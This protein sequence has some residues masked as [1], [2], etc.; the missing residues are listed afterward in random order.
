MI[1]GSGEI[2]K[3]IKEKKLLEG[4]LDENIEGAGVDL[5]IDKIFRLKSGA[6]LTV[7]E[8]VLPKLEE[9]NEK[10]FVLKPGEYVLIQTIEKVNIPLELCAR[11]L[12][13]STLQRSGVYQFHSFIDPGYNGVL[14]FGMKNLGKYDFEF[15]KG[16]RVC[17]II[18]EEVKGD[19]KAYNGKYQGGKTF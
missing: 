7:S 12:P 10:Q 14:T 2:R 11:M 3:L 17:Q 4:H 15:E 1:L 13:R 18:F 19:A 5:R 9:V 6:R 8:R 16:T